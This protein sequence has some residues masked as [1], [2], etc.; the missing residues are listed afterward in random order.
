M[1]LKVLDEKH[2]LLFDRRELKALVVSE[3][4]PNRLKVLDLISKK[5]TC[6]LENIK[7]TGIKGGFGT[8]DFIIKANVY[9][10]KENMHMLELKKK[11]ENHPSDAELKKK[12]T[13]VATPVSVASVAPE[14]PVEAAPE[15]T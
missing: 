2:N 10:S 11:K 3:V 7:I 4:T 14:K 1:E 9:G 8:N 13:A 5:F 6:P 12:E 15:S